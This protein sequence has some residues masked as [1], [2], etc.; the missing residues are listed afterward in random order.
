MEP[1]DADPAPQTQ[2]RRPIVKRRWAVVRRASGGAAVVAIT[3]ALALGGAADSLD[4]DDQR[5][6]GNPHIAA[7]A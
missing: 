6:G 1:Q 7:D 4:S 2:P 5:P 3:G